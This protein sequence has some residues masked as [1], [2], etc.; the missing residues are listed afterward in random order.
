MISK[1]IVELK[2]KIVDQESEIKTIWSTNQHKNEVIEEWTAKCH[3]Q[4]DEL[5]Q[6]DLKFEDI[7]CL[8]SILFLFFF[9]ID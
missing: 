6:A 1:Q 5:K 4:E 9:Y 7:S 8:K 2:T 3:R